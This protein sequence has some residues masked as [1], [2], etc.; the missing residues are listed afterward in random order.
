MPEFWSIFRYEFRM[1][2]QRKGLWLAYGLLFI[3]YFVAIILGRGEVETNPLTIKE[4][5]SSSAQLAFTF[6]LFLPVVAGISA[7]DRLVRDRVLRTD[8]LLA[9]TA[10]KNPTYLAGKYFGVLASLLLPVFGCILAMRVYTLFLGVPVVLLGMTV[11]TFMVVVVPAYAFITAFSLACP[12]VMPVRVY[13]VLFTGYWFWGNFLSPNVFPT[14]SGTLLQ[15]GGKVAMEGLFG[16]SYGGNSAYGP[17]DVWIN[18]ALLAVCI[19]SALFAADQ[20]LVRKN[21]LA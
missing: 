3:F 14:L 19:V 5:W 10:L 1:S 9:S 17:T 20:F 6:N 15:A 13:Q 4:L 8:E 11:A 2:I 16:V 21:R 7:A 12:L 18:F